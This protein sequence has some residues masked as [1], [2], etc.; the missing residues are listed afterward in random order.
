METRSSRKRTTRI[1]K[2]QLLNY[3]NFGDLSEDSCTNDL[4]KKRKKDFL[5]KTRNRKIKQQKVKT[6]KLTQEEM[7]TYISNIKKA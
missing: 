1:T 6:I 7:E 5:K 4:Y 3:R 2:E